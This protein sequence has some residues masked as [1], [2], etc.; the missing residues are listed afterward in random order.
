[1][2]SHCRPEPPSRDDARHTE[3]TG[4]SGRRGGPK[5]MFCPWKLVLH[6]ASRCFTADDVVDG[7]SIT[8]TRALRTKYS[9]SKT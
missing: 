2:L 8:A 4:T 5:Q 6:G 9:M 7:Q 1:M 3:V